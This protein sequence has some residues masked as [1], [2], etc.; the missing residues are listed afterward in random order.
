MYA[1]LYLSIMHKYTYVHIYIYFLLQAQ[2][3][4]NSNNNNNMTYWQNAAT[5]S[6]SRKRLICSKITKLKTQT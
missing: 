4:G 3:C 1:C 5:I 2:L 6:I